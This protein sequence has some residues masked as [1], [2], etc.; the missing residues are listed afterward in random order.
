[1]KRILIDTNIIIDLLADRQPFAA[2][3]KTI[4]S[5]A[6][7]EE[8]QVVVSS[9]SIVNTHYILHNVHKIKDARSILS[10]FRA[11]VET[12]HLS[13]KTIEL[14]LNE[15]TFKD[16]KDAVQYFTAIESKCECIVTRNLKDFKNS[17]LPVFGPNE[18]LSRYDQH[19]E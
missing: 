1:M 8:I 10:K 9:L 13:D 14:A 2:A 3:S 7:T 11:L 5:L 18:Y 12:A 17:K 19:K 16:F 6:D 4:F 15:L